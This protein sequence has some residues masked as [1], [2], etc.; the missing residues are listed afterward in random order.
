M[1][2][3]SNSRAISDQDTEAAPGKIGFGRRSMLFTA[4]RR[5]IWKWH[6]DRAALSALRTMNDR[7]LR[8][9]GLSRTDILAIAA[10]ACG[11][12]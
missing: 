4:L 3:L 9:I 1:N 5:R 8:D 2:V 10:N 6:Q 11:F 12:K 7:D